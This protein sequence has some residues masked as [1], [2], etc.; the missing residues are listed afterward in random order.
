MEEKAINW[1]LFVR[2]KGVWF[3][4]KREIIMKIF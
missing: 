4:E 3:N 2:E 1:I